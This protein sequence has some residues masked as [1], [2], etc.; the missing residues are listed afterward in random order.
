MSKLFKKILN[1]LMPKGGE[2]FCSDCDLPEL[3]CECQEE[4]SVILI[5]AGEN[6]VSVIKAIR[7]ATGYGLKE[8]K[9]IADLSVVRPTMVKQRLS[10]DDA[11]YLHEQ[12]VMADAKTH[13]T[14]DDYDT[15]MQKYLASEETREPS[16]IG[17]LIRRQMGA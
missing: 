10:H 8:A 3:E 5:D 2:K 1:F 14:K 4:W 15:F 6:K 16:T 12:L 13:I 17:E 11:F 7:A 9:D